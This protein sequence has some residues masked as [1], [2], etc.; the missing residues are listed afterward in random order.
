MYTELSQANKAIIAKL[1]EALNGDADDVPDMNK[2]FE[3]SDIE[4]GRRAFELVQLFQRG[5]I[6]TVKPPHDWFMV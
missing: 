6:A 1:L 5:R 2:F 3:L 4:D